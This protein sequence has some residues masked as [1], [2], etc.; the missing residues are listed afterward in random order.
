MTKFHPVMTTSLGLNVIPI[1]DGQLVYE[2]SNKKIYID[3]GGK[4]QEILST[5]PNAVHSKLVT[6]TSSAISTI[7]AISG[8]AYTYTL[9]GDEVITFAPTTNGYSPT[10]ELWLKM[11]STA[12]TFSFGTTIVW[13]DGNGRFSSYNPAPDFSEGG[14]VY[15]LVFQYDETN[16]LGNLVSVKE[17]Q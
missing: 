13:S 1:N 8:I 3:I 10:F 17:V 6:L 7:P 16:W 14:V 2:S 4:R 15:R 5:D 12:V 9:T 11:P